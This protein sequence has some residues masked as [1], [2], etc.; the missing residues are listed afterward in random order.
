MSN[1]ISSKFTVATVS[2]ALS[3]IACQANSSQAA[4]VTYDFSI[5][6]S[7]LS[8]YTSDPSQPGSDIE[9]TSPS[10]LGLPDAL[11]GSFQ[12]NDDVLLE[13]PKRFVIS[14]FELTAFEFD[15]LGLDSSGNLTPRR[16]FL[17]DLEYPPVWINEYIREIVPQ[18][19]VE[20]SDQFISWSFGEV[21]R[22]A[23]FFS[24]IETSDSTLFLNLSDGGLSYDRRAEVP[25][26]VPEPNTLTGLSLLGL[27]WLLRKKIISSKPTN[28]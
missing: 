11:Q 12:F 23:G 5:D 9:F 27:G 6:T 21:E 25:T 7:R 14:G 3:L 10:E 19:D 22:G 24:R 1:N 4:T 15:F 20:Y 28:A 16:Y 17:D 2:A 13:N 18:I 8:L 26:S